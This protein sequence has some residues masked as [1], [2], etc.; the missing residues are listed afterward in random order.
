[1]GAETVAARTISKKAISVDFMAVSIRH[2]HRAVNRREHCQGQPSATGLF[3]IVEDFFSQPR[4]SF[5][6]YN[7]RSPVAPSKARHD[8]ASS[9]IEEIDVLRKMRK[10]DHEKLGMLAYQRVLLEKEET[11]GILPISEVFE[12][13]NTGILKEHLEY[14]DVVRAVQ[15]LKKKKVIPEVRTLPDGVIEVVFFSVQHTDDEAK[16]ISLAS[17]KGF[18]SLEEICAQLNWSQDRALRSLS[19]LESSGFAKKDESYL[20]GKKWYFPSIT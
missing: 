10:I 13:V 12:L 1:M 15:I 18:V 2:Y 4:L 20:K 11:G 7:S 16:V 3:E 8:R 19:S 17:E 9:G 5:L 6:P 14:E